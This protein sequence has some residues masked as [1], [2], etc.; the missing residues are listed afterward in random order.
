M[1]SFESLHGV[2]FDEL[3]RQGAFGV[4]A[5]LLASALLA[6]YRVEERRP[7]NAPESTTRCVN[8]ACDG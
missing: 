4:D 2:I 6:K 8:G 3:E 5:V 1:A 7:R